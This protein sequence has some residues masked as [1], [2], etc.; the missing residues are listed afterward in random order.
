M[1]PGLGAIIGSGERTW[2][3]PASKRVMALTWL[4]ST[5]FGATLLLRNRSFVDQWGRPPLLCGADS[6]AVIVVMVVQFIFVSNDAR[7]IDLTLKLREVLPG[8]A[9][10][11]FR[12]L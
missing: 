3:E 2:R 5:V 9:S 7:I 4:L 12:L 1:A 8:A 10:P 6:H 11:F